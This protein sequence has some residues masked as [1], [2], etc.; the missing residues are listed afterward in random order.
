LNWSRTN[1]AAATSA[2]TDAIALREAVYGIFGQI[3][4]GREAEPTDLDRLNDALTEAPMRGAVARIGAGIA[5]RIECDRTIAATCLRL[6]CGPPAI[7]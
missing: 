5:W 4:S 3:A 7:F 2:F 6:W 1:P